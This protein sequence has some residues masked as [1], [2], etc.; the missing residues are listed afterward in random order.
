MAK[1]LSVAELDPVFGDFQDTAHT[2]SDVPNF[3]LLALPR[4]NVLAVGV[5]KTFWIVEQEKCP[6]NE[7]AAD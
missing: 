6:V 5:L 2:D 7:S 4:L 1:A 3:V